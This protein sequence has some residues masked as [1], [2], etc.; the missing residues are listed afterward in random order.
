MIKRC[1]PKFIISEKDL[2]DIEDHD[3]KTEVIT[4]D[5]FNTNIF[6]QHHK[7]IGQ[8]FTKDL[9]TKFGLNMKITQ[10]LDHLKVNFQME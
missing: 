7:Y 3:S 4:F 1:S 9:E 5:Y 8:K 2:T 10:L 6:F